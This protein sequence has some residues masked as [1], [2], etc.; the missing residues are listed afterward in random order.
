MV[1]AK[2]V[3]RALVAASRAK[4]MRSGSGT[5]RAVTAAL[6]GEDLL[7]V[8]DLL[9]PLTSEVAERDAA[10][11]A[12]ARWAAAPPAERV[13]TLLLTANRS[14]RAEIN[15]AVQAELKAA[16]DIASAGVRVDVL[17]RVKATCEG[18]RLKISY[19]P[20]RVV[21]FRTD[22]PSY[23]FGRGD[24]GTAI[25][26]EEGQVRLAMR[27]GREK[28]FWLS[29]L[30]ALTRI[31]DRIALIVD[32]GRKVERGVAG[33]KASAAGGNGSACGPSSRP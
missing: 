24:H 25:G 7:A 14:M 2:L 5:M 29:F 17:D 16:G 19:Q 28:I 12:A 8:F 13:G 23:G 20:G 1:T 4:T 9:A 22:L 30:V 21:E 33:D 6:D 18:A 11:V 32:D 27:D 26:T 31:T 15:R 3:G 10:V